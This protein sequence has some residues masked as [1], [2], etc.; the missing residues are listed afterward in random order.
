MNLISWFAI[1]CFLD[2]RFGSLSVD[3]VCA[4]VSSLLFG[5]CLGC[6]KLVLCLFAMLCVQPSLKFIACTCC[7]LFLQT[8]LV[9]RFSALLLFFSV[10]RA[11]S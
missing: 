2:V 7:D 8:M 10:G 3:F 1:E 9:F 4:C 6:Q 5:V 11:R